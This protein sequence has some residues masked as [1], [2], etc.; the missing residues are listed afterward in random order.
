[1][2]E[3]MRMKNVWKIELRSHNQ[4]SYTKLTKWLK[5][6]HVPLR[7][8]RGKI[9]TYWVNKYVQIET[10]HDSFYVGAAGDLR[11]WEIAH[12]IFKTFVVQEYPFSNLRQVRIDIG[13]QY[14][15]EGILGSRITYAKDFLKKRSLNV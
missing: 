15:D 11:A 13:N 14:N 7:P 4:M 6:N 2:I 12:L 8:V 3:E 10:S 9:D 5:D 1:M